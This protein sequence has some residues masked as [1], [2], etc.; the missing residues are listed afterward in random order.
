MH[1]WMRGWILLVHMQERV[2]RPLTVFVGTW[3]LG[4][5]PPPADLSPWL[6]GVAEGQHDLVAIGV[7]VGPCSTHTHGQLGSPVL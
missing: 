2:H 3:N 4:N 6:Q 5:A 7:Q 1:A